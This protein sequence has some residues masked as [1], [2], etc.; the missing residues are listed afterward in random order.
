MITRLCHE[1]INAFYSRSV[2]NFKAGL[3]EIEGIQRQRLKE[4]LQNLK[5]TE[6]WRHL[7][8]HSYEELK[9]I[10]PIA[11]YADYEEEVHRQKE[12]GKNLL[13]NQVV[14][15]EPTSG[16]TETRKW[17]PYSSDFLSEVN[18][19]AAIWLGDVYRTYPQVK[20]GTHYWSLSWL[21]QELRNL[22]SSDDAELFPFYQRW[23]LKTT[24]AVSG[25]I[26]HLENPDAAW[27]AT[28]MSL[29]ADKNLS[30]VSVWSPTFWLKI[31][32]DMREFWPEI[33]SAL[34]KGRWGRH[35]DEI[36]KILGAA[37]RR[38]ALLSQTESNF[39]KKLWPKLSLI[40]AW[41]SSSS[42]HWANEIKMLFPDVGFQGK[43]LWAT[44]GVLTVPFQ[45]KKVL[46][47]HAHFYE[48]RD[49]ENGQ[50][51][52][53]WKLQKD[54]VYQPILWTSSGLLRYQLQDRIKVTGFLGSTPHLE[55]MGR[56]HSVD[57][58]G[59]KVDAAWVQT[60]FSEKPEW[61]ALCL[62]A[63]RQPEPHYVLINQS[64][65]KIDIE[66]ELLKL[67]H[68]KVARELGQLQEAKCF[69]VKDIFEFF[70]KVSRIGVL[71]QNKLEVLLERDSL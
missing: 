33:Q 5:D 36:N 31:V 35:D 22:T 53:S 18:K 6:K 41:D 65:Q 17:I 38:T 56:L 52:P 20:Q 42:Q 19:A 21:P 63:C 1:L 58:V 50:I 60:L 25:K 32:K 66:H 7:S 14:R 69:A 43:G 48:F 61:K 8:H 27:W 9:K 40:S 62:L 13:S 30:L 59:E 4:I 11:T 71:G 29:A 44:E 67:H 3:N 70:D 57:L 68:Y 64:E 39:L 28:L 15:Y 49:L 12:T 23:I 34:K 45:D 26:A 16:S 2:E 46:T 47:I 10:V 37:P 51:F 24:M 55:F 54:R